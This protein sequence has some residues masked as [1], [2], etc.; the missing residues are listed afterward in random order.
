MEPTDQ[1]NPV[2]VLAEE[3][4]ERQRRGE[5][6]TVAEYADTNPALAEE[7]RRLFPTILAM[8]RVKKSSSSFSD[9]PVELPA[10]RLQQLGDYRLV[11]EIGR[12]GMGIV[13]VLHATVASACW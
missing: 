9:C 1:R 8:E 7:I 12:G 3:F 4:I 2:E 11:R 13:R 6:P 10:D 5:H